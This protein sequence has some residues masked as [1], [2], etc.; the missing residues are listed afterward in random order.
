[1]DAANTLDVP[2]LEADTDVSVLVITME[3][4]CRVN[5]S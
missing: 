5:V 2:M 4:E 1:M 3:R